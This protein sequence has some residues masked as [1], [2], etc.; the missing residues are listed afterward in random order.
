M[1]FDPSVSTCTRRDRVPDVGLVR[2]SQCLRRISS[3]VF[4]HGI[5]T[6]K[7]ESRA[8]AGDNDRARRSVYKLKRREATD[9]DNEGHKKREENRRAYSRVALDPPASDQPGGVV[10]G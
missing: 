4:S 8:R 3:F 2:G 1:F 7:P 5:D 6:G 10:A 9:R